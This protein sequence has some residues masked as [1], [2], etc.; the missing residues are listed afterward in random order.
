MTG[1]IGKIHR[2]HTSEMI[3][4]SLEEIGVKADTQIRVI[5]NNNINTVI[6]QYNGKPIML[7]RE[8]ALKIMIRD[9]II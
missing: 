6:I 8:T 5:E 9:I 4:K 2:F 1:L 7:T 3:T